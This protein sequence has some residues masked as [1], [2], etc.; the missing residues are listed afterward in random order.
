MRVINSLNLES[1]AQPLSFITV[2]L[3]YLLSDG[4]L[5]LVHA[6]FP[7]PTPLFLNPF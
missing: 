4:D 3:F 6:P 7:L 5:E 1:W 2:L